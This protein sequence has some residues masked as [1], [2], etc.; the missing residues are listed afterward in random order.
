MFKIFQI[1]SQIPNK[2][3][4]ELSLR[5][6]LVLDVPGIKDDDFR[7]VTIPDIV[8]IAGETLPLEKRLSG[9]G[10]KIKISIV[11]LNLTCFC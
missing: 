11:T 9:L 7:R 2:W 4:D 8:E 1:A 3:G 6:P 5:M 10:P